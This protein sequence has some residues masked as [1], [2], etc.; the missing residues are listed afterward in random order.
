MLSAH[1][2]FTNYYCRLL[3]SSEFCFKP[4]ALDVRLMQKHRLQDV[5]ATV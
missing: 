1:T 5:Y 4:C 2:E 3:I